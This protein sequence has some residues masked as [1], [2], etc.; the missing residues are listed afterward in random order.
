MS[1][2]EPFA[3]TRRLAAILAADVAGYSRLMESDE[4]G[5][6]RRLQAHRR[7]VIDPKIREHQGRIVKTTG[8]GLLAEFRSVVDAVR[9]AVEMQR[10]IAECEA[11]L[12]QGRE[13]RFRIGINLGDIIVDRGDIFG[14]GVNIAARLEALAEPGGLCI[15]ETVRE[16]LGGRL[17]Y[18]F[19]DIGEQRVKN[20]A[21]PLRVYAMSA[22]AAAETPLAPVRQPSRF[23]LT[24]PRAV[25][26]AVCL[27]LALIGSG[28]WLVWP[29]A[30]VPPATIGKPDHGRLSIA[31]L[32]FA[33]LSNDAGQDLFTDAVTDDLTTDLAR[34]EESFVIARTIAATYKGQPVDVKKIGRE[35]GVRYVL[36][37]SMR[38]TGEQIE[39][40]AQLIDAGTGAQV[41]SDRFTSDATSTGNAQ[42]EITGRL[43]RTVGAAL[44]DAAA[45]EIERLEKPDARDL[46]IRG[47]AG[48]YR[49][50]TPER[51]RDRREIFERA[52]AIDPESVEARV[53]IANVLLEQIVIGTSSNRQA[54]LDRADKLLT[55]AL[56]RNRNYSRL[57][58]E[59]G[60]LRRQQGRIEE[61]RAEYE[62]T[63]SLDPNNA[64]ATMQ[65]GYALVVSRPEAALPYF[66]KALRLVG[67]SYHNVYFYY[68][69]LGSCH[70]LLG[71]LDEG[72]ELLNKAKT[73]NARFFWVH[74][75]LAA[76][77]GL[78]G[79]ID[80]ARAALADMMQNSPRYR[81]VA[82]L[83][84]LPGARM[85]DPATASL[86]ERTVLTGLRRAGMPEE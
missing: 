17:P 44:L 77:Y 86:W 78:R 82:E 64:T 30:P 12:P 37:G 29:G 3:G 6:L 35:L 19:V 15:S 42:S 75:Y 28:A 34:I 45:R 54:D 13:L 76:A 31:V 61:S 60:M 56:A 53:G 23:G 69:G 27:A 81:T 39:T 32:P 36:A 18:A 58:L 46:V 51:L 24:R 2:A 74:L 7:E 57:H 59:L 47:W 62:T 84:K 33:N 85:S 14:D 26:I 5:T 10:G 20:I 4:E 80:E 22:A 65:M 71:H 68:Y 83:R 63:L 55:E 40:N 41:W 43:T 25:A 70:V 52:L 16:H 50:E 72:I 49:P 8:D 67:P 38:R 21:R 1:L 48:F 9:C 73:A 79:D 66:Q 11:A